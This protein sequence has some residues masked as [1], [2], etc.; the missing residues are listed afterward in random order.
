MLKAA[1]TERGPPKDGEDNLN[2]VSSATRAL[3]GPYVTEK[4]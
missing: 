1:T 2:S 3:G 4:L